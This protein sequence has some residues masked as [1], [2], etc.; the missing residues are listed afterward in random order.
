[1][2]KYDVALSWT[3]EYIQSLNSAEF[4]N[5]YVIECLKRILIVCSYSKTEDKPNYSPILF[6]FTKVAKR[7]L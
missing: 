7:K 5:F 4:L 6:T 2:T 3:L 1:M